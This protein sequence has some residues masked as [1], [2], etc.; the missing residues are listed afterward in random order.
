MLMKSADKTLPD[1]GSDPIRAA[2]CALSLFGARADGQKLQV[3]G[4]GF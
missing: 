2:L 1:A 3:I 4:E